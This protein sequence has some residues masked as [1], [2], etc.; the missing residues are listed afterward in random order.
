MVLIR[1]AVLPVAHARLAGKG[2]KG[3]KH[4]PRP[5][6]HTPLYV[7]T[8]VAASIL[9]VV[10][11]GTTVGSMLPFVLRRFG[12]D[13]ASASAPLVATIVDASGLVVYFTVAG[14][15]LRALLGT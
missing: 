2:A 4:Q 8:A 11:W 3:T 9:C 12:A 10:L 14:M 1:T 15:V 6:G 7:S 13:P 5:V